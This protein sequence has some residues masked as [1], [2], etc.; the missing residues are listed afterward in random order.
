MRCD[1]RQ[2][3]SRAAAARARRLA[4]LERPQQALDLVR[5]HAGPVVGDADDRHVVAA[6]QAD[7]DVQRARLRI[8]PVAHRIGQQVV[9]GAV[10]FGPV[11][12]HL[13]RGRQAQVDAR[14]TAARRCARAARPPRAAARVRRPRP[15]PAVPCARSR[16]TD[17][18]CCRSARCRR[19]SQSRDSAGT[20]AISTSRRRRVSGVRR[21]CEMPA[22]STARS[23][24]SLPRSATMRL[25]LSLTVRISTGPVSGSGAGGRPL[26]RSAAARESCASGRLISRVMRTAPI[27][28]SSSATAAQPIHCVPIRARGRIAVDEHPVPVVVERQA[29]PQPAD[30]VHRRTRPGCRDRAARR[31]PFAAIWISGPSVTG[32]TASVGSSG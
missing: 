4:A 2:A 7:G 13:H 31:C 11:P 8:A 19:P 5:R 18:R 28:D 23:A 29:H 16:G 3:E 10:Q 26:P 27:S 14:L 32:A 24:S 6:Q 15:V 17:A 30:A 25:K 22:S 1:D 12:A 9:D 20:L 21:S